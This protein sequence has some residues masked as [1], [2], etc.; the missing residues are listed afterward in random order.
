MILVNPAARF[1]IQGNTAQFTAN[2]LSVATFADFPA[3]VTKMLANTQSIHCAFCLTCQKICQRDST[4]RI[5]RCCPGNVPPGFV[6]SAVLYFH[7]LGR[8]F[9][10]WAAPVRPPRPQGGAAAPARPARLLQG[11]LSPLPSYPLRRVQSSLLRSCA[12]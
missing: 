7:S 6:F 12:G 9:K 3:T 10:A 5:V 11:V 2:A 4:L 8:C 1:R